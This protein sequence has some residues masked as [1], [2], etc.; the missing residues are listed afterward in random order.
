M[1]AADKVGFSRQMA[2]KQAHSASEMLGSQAQR[3]PTV[4]LAPLPA[5]L[6]AFRQYG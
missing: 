5:Q 1:R 3:Q 6:T 2:K 4:Q